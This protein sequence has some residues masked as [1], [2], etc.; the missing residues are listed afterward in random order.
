MKNYI[1]KTGILF[2]LFLGFIQMSIAD[3]PGPPPPPDHGSSGNT[4]AGAP[5]DGG[6]GIL[7]AMG[8]SYGGV[9]LYKFRNK[10]KGEEI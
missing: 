6:L 10:N 1:K 7:L 3:P 8:A 5:I 4:P 9:K 2:V